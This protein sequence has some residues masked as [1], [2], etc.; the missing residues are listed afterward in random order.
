MIRHI[1]KSLAVLLSALVIVGCSTYERSPA[2]QLIH[3]PF[4]ITEDWQI[5]Q[6]DKPLETIPYILSLD[7]LIDMNGY[8]IEENTPKNKYRLM[9]ANYKRLHGDILVMPEIILLNQFGKEFRTTYKSIGSTEVRWRSYKYLG[10]GTNPD[11]GK[12]YYP[13]DTKI[14]ALKVR[15]NTPMT[16]E[17]FDW[18]VTGYEMARRQSWENVPPSKIVSFDYIEK[19]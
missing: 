6:L 5:I 2:D 15:A 19:E 1:S 18:N 7:V 8:E 16:V 12:F 17:Y 14:V 4:E 11:L 10:Y 3:G 9:S 13:K